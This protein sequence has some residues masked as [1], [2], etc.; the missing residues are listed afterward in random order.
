[1]CLARSSSGG[2]Y[3]PAIAAYIDAQNERLVAAG[4]APAN[5]RHQLAVAE[6]QL[7][8]AGIAVGDGWVDPRNMLSAYAPMMFNQ[9]MLSESEAAQVR[10]TCCSSVTHTHTHTHTRTHA[11]I[12]THTHAHTHTHTHTHVHTHTHTHT[13]THLHTLTHTHTSFLRAVLSSDAAAL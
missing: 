8:L 5:V 9:G 11:N 3:V 6:T 13:H 12:R 4:E 7:P 10:S 2:H 1:M